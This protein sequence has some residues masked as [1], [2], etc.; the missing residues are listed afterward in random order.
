MPIVAGYDPNPSRNLRCEVAFTTGPDDPNPAWQDLT[1]RLDLATGLSITRGRGD[2]FSTVQ[3]STCSATL[4]NRDGALTPGNTGSTFYPNVRPYRKVR[5][6]YRNPA[7]AGN[8]VDAASASLEAGTGSWVNTVG[9]SPVVTIASSSTRAT[10]GTKSLLITWPAASANTVAAGLNVSGLVIGRSYTLSADVYRATGHP[11]V[12]LGIYFGSSTT[13][14]VADAFGRLTLSFTATANTHTIVAGNADAATVG[15]QAWVDAIMVDEGTNSTFTTTA[16]PIEYRFTG[17]V[18]EWPVEWPNGGSYSQSTIAATDRF[19]RIGAKRPMRS[20]IEEAILA[21][22][23]WAYY[24][25]GEPEE[26]TMAGETSGRGGT[27]LATRQFGAGGTLTFGTATGPPTDALPAPTF[28][29]AS[30]TNGLALSGN[31]LHYGFPDGEVGGVFSAGIRASF[32]TSAATTQTIV[33]LVDSYGSYL[34]VGTNS[35]GKATLVEF[36]VW[37]GT[38][39]TSLAS[40][41][42]VNN[43]NT[44]DI[45]AVQSNSGGTITT[46]LYV[47]GASVASTSRAGSFL[48]TYVSILIGGAADST[49]FA[50]TISHVAVHHAPLLAADA[51]EVYTAT[52][53]GYE[54]ERS[55]QRIQRYARWAGIDDTEMVLDTGS[56]T[57][58]CFT[59]TTGQSVL[60]AMQDVAQTEGGRL[61]IDGQGRLVF[62][63]RS[64]TYDN[65][66]ATAS[67]NAN[68]LG[69]DTRPS[70]STFGIYN[71]VTGQRPTGPTM[72]A[73]DTDSVEEYGV[74]EQSLTLLVTTDTE[75]LDAVNWRV[76]TSATPTVRLP[77]GTFDLYT[78]STGYQAQ[79]RSLELG[80]RVTVTGMP[81]QMGSTT[82]DFTLEGYTE[83]VG[84]GGWSLAANLSNYADVQGLV[85]DDVTFGLLDGDNRLIY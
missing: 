69:A 68:L 13:S 16:P 76:S 56:S 70:E 83:T 72:R 73:T 48:P 10:D 67:V 42:S 14:T 19:A 34:R 81:T 38:N 64:R 46:T 1:S 80:D 39:V 74:H 18:E 47:D 79:L 77:Q 22:S 20:V 9:G 6:S 78:D 63:A 65:P 11:R 32:L 29:P 33:R 27:P 45:C 57:S 52:S 24:P 35:S 50:G 21:T 28:T 37:S 17:N 12:T 40:S 25:M 4:D 60:Q 8:L 61:F 59:D 82:L 75:V 55:D 26:S 31:L 30:S 5:F 43:G 66:A 41:A 53:T 49:M 62:H 3:P 84:V 54:G 85:L 23:P 71:D 44:H 51:L 7:V 15:Q 58:I 36:D 2:E